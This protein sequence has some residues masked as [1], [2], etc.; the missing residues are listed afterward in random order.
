MFEPGS[1]VSAEPTSTKGPQILQVLRSFRELPHVVAHG[2]FRKGSHFWRDLLV[3]WRR[4]VCLCLFEVSA[5]LPRL[6]LDACTIVADG[7]SLSSLPGDDE[8]LQLLEGSIL[9]AVRLVVIISNHLV[10]SMLCTLRRCGQLREGRTESF[11]AGVTC[12][13]VRRQHRVRPRTA[14]QPTSPRCAEQPSMFSARPELAEE[15]VHEEGP[16]AILALH[17]FATHLEKKHRCSSLRS[18]SSASTRGE[19]RKQSPKR[20]DRRA[21][22]P[23]KD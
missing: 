20:L 9:A 2:F 1:F 7:R 23:S 13:S 22:R 5:A 10:D 16:S 18:A 17:G 15:K 19:R 4:D 8:Q 6:G 14:E 11:G 3:L 12:F 21:T